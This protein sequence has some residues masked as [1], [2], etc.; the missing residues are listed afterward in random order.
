MNDELLNVIGKRV[1][2]DKALSSPI[3]ENVA[4]RWQDILKQGL[5]NDEKVKLIKKYPTPE[6][7]TLSEPPKLNAEIK[8]I[9]HESVY[10]GDKR[11]VV[12]QTKIT[13]CLAAVGKVISL[14]LKTEKTK[15]NVEILE[16]LG[17]TGS[18]LADLQHDES[19]ISRSLIIANINPELKETLTETKPDEFLFSNKLDEV[20]KSA[21]ALKSSSKDLQLGKE[22]NTSKNWK[23]PPRQ[24]KKNSSSWSGSRQYQKQHPSHKRYSN[25][26]SQKPRTKK[27]QYQRSQSRRR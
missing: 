16:C 22:K 12:K 1:C 3:Q 13:S 20:L 4:L 18:F 2:E 25:Y 6:N 26:H 27:E 17:D 15:E 24:Q 21:K 7:L 23:F 14:F 11:I 5:P 9:I 19:A 8:P 10:T